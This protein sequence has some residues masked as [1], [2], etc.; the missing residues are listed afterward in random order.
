[1]EG[2]GKMG[3][4]EKME[5]GREEWCGMMEG[6]GPKELTHLLGLPSP[7]SA[8]GRWMMF[9][10]SRLRGWLPPLWVFVFVSRRWS[11]W[12]VSFSL[13]GVRLH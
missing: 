11:S 2:G 3:G 10:G 5:G 1:M 7:V 8:H 12:V 13:A 4:G 6:E 9:A